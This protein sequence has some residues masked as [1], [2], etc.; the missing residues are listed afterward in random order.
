M[1]GLEQGTPEWHAWRR[2][3]IGASEMPILLGVGPSRRTVQSLW[4]EKVDGPAAERDNGAMR[5]GRDLEAQARR[6]AER[7]LGH[8]FE[9]ACVEW[10]A[11]PVLR[12]SVDGITFDGGDVLEVKCPMAPKWAAIARAGEPPP[13]YVVQVQHQLLVTGAA[14]AIIWCWDP[15]HGGMHWAIA[16]DP[17]LAKRIMTAARRFWTAV[18]TR[19]AP[20]MEE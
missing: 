12:A 1:T 13:E 16:P 2:A 3:G 18:E 4:R 9:P 10:P 17:V 11:W 19:T 20:Q 6:A 7:M 8:L 15:R 5:R 14:R